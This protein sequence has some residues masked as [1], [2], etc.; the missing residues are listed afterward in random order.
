[1]S[2]TIE[3]QTYYEDQLRRIEVGKT[4]YFPTIKIFANGN[5]ENTNHMDLNAD[6]AQVLIKWLTD[7]FINLPR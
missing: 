6:S 4:P 7:N 2:H 5:G 3:Y 1:M